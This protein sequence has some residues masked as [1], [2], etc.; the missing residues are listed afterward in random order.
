MCRIS[1]WHVQEYRITAQKLEDRLGVQSLGTYLVR[2]R[3]WWLGHVRRMP[4][5]RLPRK[6]ATD[7]MGGLT[8]GGGGAGDDV[9]AQYPRGLRLAEAAGMVFPEAE[10]EEQQAE[11]EEGDGLEALPQ[12][13]SYGRGGRCSEWCRSVGTD[14][15]LR[16]AGPWVEALRAAREAAQSTAAVVAAATAAAHA[17]AACARTAVATAAHA[18]RTSQPS[19]SAQARDARFRR[20]ATR[21]AS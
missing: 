8:A 3:L 16:R 6:L 15:A 18:V 9:R 12:C 14:R 13:R 19:E 5:N 7:G 11:P 1:M 10:V 2:R 20:L 4:W 17:A 21:S